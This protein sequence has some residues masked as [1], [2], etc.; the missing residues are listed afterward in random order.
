[1]ESMAFLDDSKTYR[2]SLERIWDPHKERVLFIMLNPSSANQDSEDATSRRCLNLI[3]NA[4]LNCWGIY[5]G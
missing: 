3:G 4:P 2:Y 5:P 1:M